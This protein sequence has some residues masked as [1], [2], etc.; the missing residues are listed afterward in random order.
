M[1]YIL[2]WRKQVECLP[3]VCSPC[4]NCLNFNVPG[5]SLTNRGQCLPVWDLAIVYS[6]ELDTVT[7]VTVAWL[8]DRGWGPWMWHGS[9]KNQQSENQDMTFKV[10]QNLEKRWDS[11][12]QEVMW[13]T[14]ICTPSW[15]CWN[16]LMC[17]FSLLKPLGYQ[18]G[19]QNFVKN[20]GIS[21]PG[22]SMI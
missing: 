18:T 3:Y 15:M 5:R 2:F 11:L 14:C 22:R 6:A 16:E 21:T 1:A 4:F 12:A 13:R 8:S 10:L 20:I 19:H 9:E 17:F 7:F